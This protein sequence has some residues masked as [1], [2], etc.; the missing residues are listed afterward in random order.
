MS[1]C[2]RFVV[3][4]T[5]CTDTFSGRVKLT[6]SSNSESDLEVVPDFWAESVADGDV[7]RVFSVSVSLWLCKKVTTELTYVL[8]RLCLSVT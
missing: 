5:T 6:D 3:M 1:D 7:Y 2:T 8:D 4:V